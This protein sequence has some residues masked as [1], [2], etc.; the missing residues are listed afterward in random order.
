MRFTDMKN[1]TRNVLGHTIR[2]VG[3]AHILCN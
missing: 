1:T 3:P 2:E